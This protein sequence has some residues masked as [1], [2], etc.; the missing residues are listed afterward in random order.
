MRGLADRAR[1]H[2]DRRLSPSGFR[3]IAVALSGGGDSLALLLIADA[4]ARTRGRDLV[5][6]TVD[7]RLSPESRA[8]TAA[9]AA[10]AARLGRPFRSLAWVGE[11]PERG[12]PAAA[13]AA[14]HRLLADAAREAGATVILM[15][16]TADDILEARRMRAAGATTPEPRVW[17]PSPA[18]PEGRG[19]FLLRPLLDIRRTELRDWLRARDETWI[20]D[21]ANLDP[22]YARARARTAG[23]PGDTPALEEPPALDIPVDEGLG[24]F[25]VD[26]VSLRDR[27]VERFVAL[28]SVCAGGGDRRPATLRL[29]RAADALRG[30]AVFV[31]VLAGARIEADAATVRIFR[32]PG[33]AARGGLAELLLQPRRPGVWDGRFEVAAEEP[34]TVRRL[35]GLAARLPKDQQLALRDVPAAARGALPAVLHGDGVCCPLLAAGPWTIRSLIG[36]RY[37]AAAGLIAREP[38]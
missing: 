28:A 15:G 35:A 17:A 36:D 9:C 3:P 1:V 31:S 23:G 26:R 5:V 25:S 24:V 16:H 7:H 29:A 4:W 30:T 20:D 18:W 13:R 6:L 27:D 8:W 37:R 19:V 22:R 34:L 32:E 38:D 33:E 14:R 2:L 10:T 12:L 21:P 11:K